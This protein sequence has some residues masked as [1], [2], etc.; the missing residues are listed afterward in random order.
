M[1]A[2]RCLPPR[3]VGQVV[4]EWLNELRE[5]EMPKNKIALSGH[6]AADLYLPNREQVHGWLCDSYDEAVKRAAQQND[7]PAVTVTA[8]FPCPEIPKAE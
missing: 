2:R 8:Q 6:V 5:S 4:Q 7:G 1:S 3:T